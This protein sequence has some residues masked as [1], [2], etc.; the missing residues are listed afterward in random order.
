[1]TQ[2]NEK[3]TTDTKAYRLCVHTVT[4]KFYEELT[5]VPENKRLKLSG[6]LIELNE[7]GAPTV[8]VGAPTASPSKAIQRE[9]AD[10][11]VELKGQRIRGDKAMRDALGIR[12]A[13]DLIAEAEKLKSGSLWTGLGNIRLN[14]FCVLLREGE[15]YYSLQDVSLLENDWE[16]DACIWVQGDRRTVCFERVRFAHSGSKWKAVVNGELITDAELIV[17]GQRL[18]ER[19]VA[20]DPA[21]NA[22]SRNAISYV[23]KRH[24]LLNP[25]SLLI[26]RRTQETARDES[27]KPIQR[28]FGLDQL[29]ADAEKLKEAIEGS[30][31]SLRLELLDVNGVQYDVRPK[32][33]TAALANK[34]YQECFSLNEL[35]Q[36]QTAGERGRYWISDTQKICYLLYHRSPY[37][38]HFL[39]A[40]E[41]G[42]TV[43]IDAVVGGFS[44]NAGCTVAGLANDLKLSGFKEALLLDNG[45]DVVLVHRNPNSG[46]VWS[47]PNGPCAI[48]PSSLGRTQWAGLMLYQAPS[49][50]GIEVRSD[51]LGKADGSYCIEWP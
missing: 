40:R 22:N 4:T 29:L 43:L 31:V 20:I 11:F 46:Q 1:M 12:P 8:L 39:A 25:Y 42:D 33:L 14:K 32:D 41:N 3:V 10:A 45:G 36:R 49:D 15:L 2:P 51:A 27:G 23:D 48:V 37:P 6:A 18:V 21:D 47:D 44:N 5:P 34:S 35:Q 30:V 13:T 16:F 19:G 17:C 9:G 26:D 50:G 7:V 28:D 38:L 24:L